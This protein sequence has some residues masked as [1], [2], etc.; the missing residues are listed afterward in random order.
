VGDPV[1]VELNLSGNLESASEHAGLG[2]P[3]ADA[4]PTERLWRDP[5]DPLLT[6]TVVVVTLLAAPAVVVTLIFAGVFFMAVLVAGVVVV[7]GVFFVGLAPGIVTVGVL[8]SWPHRQDAS[9]D[10]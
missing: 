2:G 8:T 3:E 9:Q 7:P 6:I 1:R 10:E 5:H 4:V